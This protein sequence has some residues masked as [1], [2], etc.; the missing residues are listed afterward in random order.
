MN[1]GDRLVFSNDANDTLDL[2][3]SDEKDLD[4]W[5]DEEFDDEDDE[6]HPLPAEC[7]HQT[8]VIRCRE[9]LYEAPEDGCFMLLLIKWDDEATEVAVA[10][11]VW[12]AEDQPP[13][14]KPQLEVLPGVSGGMGTTCQ[15]VLLVW[16]DRSCGSPHVFHACLPG[17]FPHRA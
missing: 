5:A 15:S 17:L 6:E 10:A 1:E 12:K 14:K 3:I 9:H 8:D 4:A 11:V 16:P 2:V 7:Y 13:R